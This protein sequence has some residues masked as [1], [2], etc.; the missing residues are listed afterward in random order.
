MKTTL[1]TEG[2]HCASCAEKI[3]KEVRCIEG[4]RAAGLDFATGMLTIDAWGDLK[5][6]TKVA[7]EI[8]IKHEPSASVRQV[9]EKAVAGAPFMAELV[10]FFAGISLLLLA[11][12]YPLSPWGTMGLYIAAY[13]IIGAKVLLRAGRNIAKGQIFDENFLMCIATLGAFAIREYPE[14]VA[15]MIFYEVGEFLQGLVVNRSRK[16]ISALM[17]IRPDYANIKARNDLQ[18]V[19]PDAVHVGDVIVILPGEK[20]PL[21]ATII[22][23]TSTLHT[24]AIT[25]ESM[26]RDVSVGSQILSGTINQSGVLHAIV[27]KEFDQSTVSKI[28]E[29]V[30]NASSKKAKTQNFITKF[31][32]VYTPVVV[33]VA[34]AMAIIPP[35]V[36]AGEAFSTW[37]YRALVFLVVSCPCALVISIPLGFFGGIGGAAKQGILMKGG[38]YLEA[39]HAV[40]TVVFDKTGTLTKGAFTVTKINCLPHITPEQLLYA[41]A[42]AQSYANHPIA[43]SIIR[44]Y[45]KDIDKSKVSEYEAIAGQGVKAL[46]D[47]K[48]VLAGNARLMGALLPPITA[49]GIGT[50]V[51]IAID[52]RYA[53]SLFI[54]DEVKE[55]AKKALAHLKALGAV[56]IVMLTGDSTEA[57]QRV[58]QELDIHEVHA[59]LLPHQKVEMVE[60]L[61]QRKPKNATLVFVGDGINDAPVLS[62]ADVGIAMGGIGSDAAIE[63]ADIVVMGDELSKIPAGIQIA[64]KTRKIVWQNILFTLTVKGA[65]LILGA[66][67]IATMWEAV[68]A[69][70]GVALLA[71]L[72]SMRM[73]KRN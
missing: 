46:V 61:S 39:L 71:V 5:S 9:G 7:T 25:G 52:G 64:R 15:V 36:F 11:L 45:G 17:N 62:R 35:L 16:S 14:A 66:I 60:M 19:S 8:I 24:S 43:T 18:R 55:D 12:F 1:Q 20:I 33:S 49:A 22:E 68:F 27:T 56:H 3:E 44:A 54:Y 57:A 53:G 37:V 72:N 59:A 23:G 13:L 28:L 69:D 2:L 73:M 40:H 70:V 4:V 65:V 6:I 32:K 41:A 47:G 48:Q 26:P 67:G 31:S 42:Y 30:Q 58:A 50:V 29:L 10:R 21:D 34:I 38:N 63:A 51:Y